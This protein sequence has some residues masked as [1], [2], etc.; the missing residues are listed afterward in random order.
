VKAAW[1]DRYGPPTIVEVRDVERPT[2]SAD[3]V[4]VRVHA[5]SVNRAD[6]DGLYPR[7]QFTRAFLGIRAPRVHGVGIDVAGTVETVGPEVTRL[8]PGD[9]VYA[10]TFA[11]GQG[12]FAEYVCVPERALRL[13]PA[14]LGFEEASTLP[15]SAVLAVQG[16]RLRNGRTVGRG[17]TVLVSGA[18]GN[19]GPFA[20]QVAKARGAEVTGS[21]STGKMDFVR[22]LGADH[23]I[24]YTMVDY[25]RGGERYDWILDVEARH[26]VVTARRALRPGGVYVS[27]GG[28]SSTIADSLLVAPFASVATGKRMGLLLWW[29]PFNAADVATVEELVASGKL[30]PRIDRRYPLDQVVDALRWV[31]EGRAT[32]K[33]I[34]TP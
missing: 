3:Q 21:S 12:T 2:P 9:R 4:L 20:V 10:D 19:V 25:A 34:V 18:S 27:L 11:F 30:V 31:D 5:A 32:G 23:V 16:L 26:S 8:R 6:I 15:H 33:V 14:N 7:W 17:D 29:K 22:S 28:P 24:D 1:R 13:I